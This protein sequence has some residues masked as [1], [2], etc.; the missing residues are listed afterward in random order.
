MTDDTQGNQAGAGTAQVESATTVTSGS[1]EA[2]TIWK[3]FSEAEKTPAQSAA[4]AS[5]AEDV[6]A[7]EK[8]SQATEE[9]KAAET[10]KTGAAAPA[11]QGAAEGAKKETPAGEGQQTKQAPD[12]WAT[13]T[14][15]QK[16]AIEAATKETT[17]L[18][19]KISSD[20][21]RIA[22]H[23]RT[24]SRLEGQL[25]KLQKDG[26]GSGAAKTEEGGAKVAPGFFETADWKATKE[27]YPDLTA[28]LEAA[29]KPLL[30]KVEGVERD[31]KGLNSERTEQE[32]A[33]NVE[34]VL[35]DHPDYSDIKGSDA[36][37]DWYEANKDIPFIAE[38]VARN[39]DTLVNPKEVSRLLKM[40]KQDTG[41]KPPASKDAGETTGDGKG[42]GEGQ[43]AASGDGKTGDGKAS[44]EGQSQTQAREQTRTETRREAQLES[45]ASPRSTGGGAIQDG[46][47]D[48]EKGAWEWY[49]RQGL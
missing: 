30:S 20:D 33:K 48:D 23:Q 45:S 25:R 32:I 5:R 11:K 12:I 36:F 2:A 19:H 38:A 29:F 15:E 49:A 31:V 16:A 9:G 41:W 13:A 40:F 37:A 42:Q 14:P 24:I 47:P 8:A 10:G 28:K 7:A 35:T 4:E 21:G 27:E 26:T 22:A 39:A 46:P 1:D 3:E 17:T 44:T 6:T 43:K 18:K 34:T